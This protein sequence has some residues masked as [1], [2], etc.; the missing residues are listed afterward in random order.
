MPLF[1]RKD[2]DGKPMLMS[3]TILSFQ[4]EGFFSWPEIFK[5]FSASQVD[6]NGWIEFILKTSGADKTLDMT[7]KL[8]KNDIREMKEKVYPM[9]LEMEKME[10]DWSALSKLHNHKQK[11]SLDRYGY[12]FMEP[13]QIELAYRNKFIQN[14]GM[15]LTEYAKMASN[16]RERLLEEDI[17]QLAKVD[18][19][20]DENGNSRHKRQASAF[21]TNT[22]PTDFKLKF[23]VLSPS[24]FT[25]RI[26]QGLILKGVI[27][28]PAAFT[29][30]INNL[31]LLTH[32]TL[33]PLAF[34]AAILNPSILFSRVLSPVTFRLEVL[35]PRIL[36][37]WVLSPS[38]FTAWILSPRI[39]QARVMSDLHFTLIILSP[40]IVHPRAGSPDGPNLSILSPQIWSPRILSPN[41]VVINVLSPPIM[42]DPLDGI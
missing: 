16:E 37:A 11:R 18:D 26:N 36:H 19:L 12:A 39:L 14:H 31:V 10:K 40:G 9:V 17:R 42:S 15:N 4:K 24:A 2:K 38:A 22:G 5:F 29:T 33:S 27:L 34:N 8:L 35:H 28:S 32:L 21:K 23:N 3:P 7:L 6:L 41:L 25:Q 30:E 20:Y 1:P 13:E